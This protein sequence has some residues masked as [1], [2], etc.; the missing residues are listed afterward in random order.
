M[1]DIEKQEKRVM[2]ISIIVTI[3]C[4]LILFVS[5]AIKDARTKNEGRVSSKETKMSYSKAFEIAKYSDVVKNKI[6]SALKLE[7]CNVKIQ[8]FTGIDY[9]DDEV[10]VYVSGNAT[11]I[12]LWN[13]LTNKDFNARV[14]IDADSKNVTAVYYG[15]E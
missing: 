2:K 10:V 3:A 9:K 7:A 13:R 8:Q 1:N 12:D 6:A 5:L 11:G 4:I 15:S 14:V